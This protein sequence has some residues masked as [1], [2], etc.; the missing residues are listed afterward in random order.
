MGRQLGDHAAAHEGDAIVVSVSDTGHKY[1][2]PVAASH[3]L[4]SCFRGPLELL[5]APDGTG[6]G[7]DA[8]RGT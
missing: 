6:S 5:S 2:T 8:N 7:P 3:S 1:A 4:A